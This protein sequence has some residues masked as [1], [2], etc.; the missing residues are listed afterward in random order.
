MNEH[1][2]PEEIRKMIYTI[3]QWRTVEALH[4]QF[5]KVT[6]SKSLFPNADALKIMLFPVYRDI[7]KKW[8][9]P[10]I[11]WSLVIPHFSIIY[12]E[13]LSTFIWRQ[14][15]FTQKILLTLLLRLFAHHEFID[16]TLEI[17][18]FRESVRITILQVIRIFFFRF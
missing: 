18:V 7:A 14:M 12:D 1:D 4:G 16:D 6:K 10:V 9:M 17:S 13:R 11:N 2:Y 5:R 3:R 15:P 8:T